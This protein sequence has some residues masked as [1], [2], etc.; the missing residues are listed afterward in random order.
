M[1]RRLST[2]D[3]QSLRSETET[4]KNPRKP[5]DLFLEGVLVIPPITVEL[6]QVRPGP[7]GKEPLAGPKKEQ[8]VMS[9]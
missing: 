7:G 5:A 2:V 9:A 1:E 3:C 8:S 4:K 6:R